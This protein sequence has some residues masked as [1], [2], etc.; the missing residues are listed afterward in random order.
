MPAILPAIAVPGL[1][2]LSRLI[3]LVEEVWRF[4]GLGVWR[5]GDLEV[6]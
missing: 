3:V 4:G 2:L 1:L 5:P 6:V